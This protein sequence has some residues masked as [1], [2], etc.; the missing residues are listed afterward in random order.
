MVGLFSIDK[1]DDSPGRH[2]LHTQFSHVSI[3]PHMGAGGDI[4]IRGKGQIRINPYLIN[5]VAVEMSIAHSLVG[6]PVVHQH[7]AG[8]VYQYRSRAHQHDLLCSDYSTA[9]RS[10]EGNKVRPLTE[11]LHIGIFHPLC[12]RPF[13][14]WAYIGGDKSE[15]KTG[16]KGSN[17]RT[18]IPCSDYTQCFSTYIKAGRADF[19]KPRPCP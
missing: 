15:P 19:G 3:R 1:I 13:F 5:T 7:P 18:D 9:P 6:S 8:A 16:Q 10:V 12:R 11:I 17:L 4:Q 14:I 2:L